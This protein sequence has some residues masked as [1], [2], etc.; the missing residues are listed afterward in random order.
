MRPAPSL[1]ILLTA[2]C[3]SSMAPVREER[4]YTPLPSAPASAPAPRQ[5]P[6]ATPSEAK[7]DQELFE[8]AQLAVEH[9]D[10]ERAR[11]TF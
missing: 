1:L 10:K 8:A 6:T 2:A 9:G 11:A 3:A 5:G 4:T 7:A